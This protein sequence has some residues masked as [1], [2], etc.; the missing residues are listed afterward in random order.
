MTVQEWKEKARGCEMAV[1]GIGVSNLPL[2]RFL[3]DCGARVTAHDR[4]TAQQLEDTYDE[5]KKLGV[6]MVLGDHYLDAVSPQAAMVFKT[7][8]I[9]YDVPALQAAAEREQG[10]HPKWSSSLSSVRPGR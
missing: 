10:S 6:A 4:R 3:A 2:I 7:P 9:R 5:L 8:G 1:I